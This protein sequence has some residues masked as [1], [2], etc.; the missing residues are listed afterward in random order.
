MLRV[1]RLSIGQKLDVE[2]VLQ[3]AAARKKNQPDT[4]APPNRIAASPLQNINNTKY[5]NRTLN[6]G[7]A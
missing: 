2:S 1:I 6:L 5:P 4:S 7:W 3:L